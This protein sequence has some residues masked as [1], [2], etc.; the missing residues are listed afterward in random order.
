MPQM[1][2]M[3]SIPGAIARNC[4]LACSCSP[5]QVSAFP[6]RQ[7]GPADGQPVALD[8]SRWLSILS[9]IFAS[10]RFLAHFSEMRLHRHVDYRCKVFKFISKPWRVFGYQSSEY[11]S[12]LG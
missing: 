8:K 11:H 3:P 2:G 6:K 10:K 7:I 1:P 5:L 12:A 4:P 9:L